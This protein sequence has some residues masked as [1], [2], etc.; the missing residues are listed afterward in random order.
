MT[1]E[2]QN[3]SFKVC[4]EAMRGHLC[5]PEGIGPFRA[6]MFTGPYTGVKE[7]V[8][9]TYSQIL[10][11]EGFVSLAFG[12]RNFGESDGVLRQNKNPQGKL[13]DL[14]AG[15]SRLSAIPSVDSAK[16]AL[17]GRMFGSEWPAQRAFPNQI[18][19]DDGTLIFG[20]S[21]A[22]QVRD[23]G[24]AETFHDSM[25]VLTYAVDKPVFAGDIAF[26]YMHSYMADNTNPARLNVH[27]NLLSD[28]S[29]N[30]GLHVG[31][32]ALFTPGFLAWQAN[33]IQLFSEDL[34]E[35]EWSNAELASA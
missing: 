1:V 34:Q 17:I 24:A 35:Q 18:V 9:G 20:P 28:L 14:A 22:F 27:E 29:E 31:Q 13:D 32:S 16:P 30:T 15:T 26:G 7:Q 4:A 11:E 33:Y 21:L 8:T 5:V 3:T 19:K 12:H 25:F 23:M 10:A 2:K 6:L